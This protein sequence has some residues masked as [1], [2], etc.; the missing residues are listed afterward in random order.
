MGSDDDV[1]AVR[2]TQTMTLLF[3][4]TMPRLLR[5]RRAHDQATTPSRKRPATFPHN[6]RLLLDAARL[7]HGTV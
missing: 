1:G 3:I 5:R 4:T 6:A 2:T 7:L